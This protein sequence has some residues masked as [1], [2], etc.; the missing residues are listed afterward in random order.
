MEPSFL[1]PA[2]VAVILLSGI[3]IAQEY[4]RAI[5][6]RL[7]RYQGIRG[8]G[9]FYLIP[10]IERQQMVDIRTRTVDLEQ[11]ETI[12]KDSVTIKVNAVL[13]Y[14]VIDP[15]KAIL[16]VANY[17]QA[18]YQFSVTTLRN[19]I[20]QHML[21]EVLREREE[22]NSKL[23]K[24]VDETTEPW[25]IKIEMVEMKDVEIPEAMQR[26]MAREA[27]AVREKRARIIKAE[28]ELEASTKLT[29]GAMQ[30]SESPIALE[31]RRLQMLSEIGIDNNT[32][33]IIMLPSEII[34]AAQK[35]AGLPGKEK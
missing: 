25:G 16:Q 29:Q 15:Q 17:N 3:R 4:Q 10:L 34:Q 2:I 28:A 31:L 21:D 6:F 1:I 26:A 27:E 32:A 30:M 12:T 9:L 33:T 7:G 35:I 23:Q 24:I 18:V 8:P 20:G 5:V 22:I 13:W 19:I 14:K 11:Q